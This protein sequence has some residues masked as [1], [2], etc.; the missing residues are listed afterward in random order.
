M[1][2]FLIFLT[3]FSYALNS[4]YPNELITRMLLHLCILILI[5]RLMLNK[6][7]YSK[8]QNISDLVATTGVMLMIPVVFISFGA[9][10]VGLDFSSTAFISNIF[11]VCLLV[12]SFYK[13][14]ERLNFKSWKRQFSQLFSGLFLKKT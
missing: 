8:K 6:V 10:F 3:L 2:C 5:T 12:F 14:K 11:A 13:I 9:Q 4:V 1:V 7:K